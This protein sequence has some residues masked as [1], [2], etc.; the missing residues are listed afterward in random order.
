MGANVNSDAG[1]TYFRR[2]SERL[3]DMEQSV[4]A[5]FGVELCFIQCGAFF[6]AYGESALTAA[7]A[8]DYRVS[9]NAHGWSMTGFP[10]SG[11]ETLME[12]MKSLGLSFAIV[13]QMGD[14]TRRGR[15]VRAVTHV[16]PESAPSTRDLRSTR[17]R[18][19]STASEKQE[20]ATHHSQPVGAP[21]RRPLKA[22]TSS[23]DGITTIVSPDGEILRRLPPETTT[24]IEWLIREESKRL[25]YPR[26]GER[27]DDAE[28]RLL[29][30]R[31]AAGAT[32]SQLAAQHRRTPGGIRSRLAKLGLEGRV[33]RR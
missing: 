32:V 11:L 8:L 17:S 2:D 6:E 18:L 14:S 30:E 23:S 9:T 24:S 20:R 12:R 28:D 16:Y 5:E 33:H 31:V 26:H 7:D 13:E 21:G 4:R 10:V 1:S 22:L 19:S 3:I 29:G 25:D 27:W 15:K